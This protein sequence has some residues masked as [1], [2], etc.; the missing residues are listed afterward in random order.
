MVIVMESKMIVK[1][2]K[3]NEEGKGIV[4]IDNNLIEIE[5][6]LPNDEIEIIITK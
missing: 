3:L 1:I 4:Y 6:A 2:E 5:G